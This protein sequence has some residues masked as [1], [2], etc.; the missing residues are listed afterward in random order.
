MKKTE[1]E[2]IIKK[3]A[4]KNAENVENDDPKKEEITSESNEG[5]STKSEN[6][7]CKPCCGKHK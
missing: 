2:G 6:S 3:F 5:A 1:S 4:L 7:S